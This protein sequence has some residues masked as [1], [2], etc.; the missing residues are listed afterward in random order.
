[1]TQTA[2][3][4]AKFIQKKCADL[5]PQTGIIL[6]SGLGEL[7]KHIDNATVIPYS[8]IPDFPP[9]SVAGHDGKLHLGTINNTAVACLEGR[10]HYYEGVNND[11]IKTPVRLLKLL[12][13]ESLLI[14]NSAG[15]L[16]ADVPTGNLVAVKDHINLQF[17]N[18]LVGPNDDDFGPRFIGM[19]DAYDKAL[20]EQLFSAAKAASIPLT[21]GVY[22]GVLGPSFETP[23]EINALRTLGADVVAM[24]L[25][26]EVII[27][28][29]CGLRVAAIS[30]IT[31]LAAG[32]HHEQLSHE[33]TLQGAKL[34]S[35]KLI[36]LVLSFLG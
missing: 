13:C 21:E 26:P 8:D 17:N 31:N 14:T 35:E 6:G 7:V 1:M 19:E 12:G 33:V 32:M 23:A 25:I 18:P 27:A 4:A 29:H 28:R 24:S 30:A 16:N 5:K 3:T 11:A 20:R 34:A 22:A 10:I 15:S 9:C 2:H 36:K